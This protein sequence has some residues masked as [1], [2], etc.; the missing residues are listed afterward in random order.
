MGRLG[1]SRGDMA[2]GTT[3]EAETPGQGKDKECT[4]EL[5]AQ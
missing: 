3:E 5:S 4:T 2:K 1:N